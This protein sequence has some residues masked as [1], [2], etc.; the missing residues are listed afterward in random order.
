VVLTPSEFASL[1]GSGMD[2]ELRASLD[3]LRVELLDGEIQVSARLH[4]DRLPPEITGPLGARWG[5]R[6]RCRRPVRCG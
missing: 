3:S 4:T 5:R 6:S 1:V 2:R